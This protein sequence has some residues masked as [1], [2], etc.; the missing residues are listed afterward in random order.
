MIIILGVPILRGF[1]IYVFEITE[2]S[3]VGFHCNQI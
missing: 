3:K 1:I 2:P